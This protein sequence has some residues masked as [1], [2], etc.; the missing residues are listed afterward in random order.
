LL[1]ILVAGTAAALSIKNGNS[2]QDI[3]IH[4]LQDKLLKNGVMIHMPEVLKTNERIIAN[5]N[6]K[7]ISDPLIKADAL[8][9]H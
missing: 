7:K 2:L 1:S 3:N 8:S 6:P 9:Y 5:L 4:N